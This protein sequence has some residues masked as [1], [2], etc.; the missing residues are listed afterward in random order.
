VVLL[1]VGKQVQQA[2]DDGGDDEEETDFDRRIPRA[3]VILVSDKEEAG[4]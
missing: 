1:D 4:R 3:L 2:V